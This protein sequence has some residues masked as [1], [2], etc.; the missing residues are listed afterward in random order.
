MSGK[1]GFKVDM[2]SVKKE[3]C[4][5][6]GKC[7]I[8]RTNEKDYRDMCKFCKWAAKIDIPKIVDELIM[9]KGYEI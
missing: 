1:Q 4:G 5:Y 7:Q 2:T 3:I 6:N 8:Y 9:K